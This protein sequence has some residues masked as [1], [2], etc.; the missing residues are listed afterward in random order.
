MMA[1]QPEVAVVSQVNE[2]GTTE[3]IETAR[4]S[5]YETE[6][7]ER[8]GEI[9][10]ISELG[11]LSTLFEPHH[12]FIV[13]GKVYFVYKKADPSTLM[14]TLGAPIAID[15]DDF[16]ALTEKED[17]VREIQRKHDKGEKIETEEIVKYNNI[18][19]SDEMKALT[20]RDLQI[21]KN[22]VIACVVA[23]KLSEED[24]D[25]LSHQIKNELY[26][27]IAGGVT[28]DNTAVQQFR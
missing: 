17:F 24:Y 28:T 15:I 19:A 11:D 2:D 23:P 9:P 10:P 5:N 25:K 3:V 18:L 21:R 26:E 7:K 4:P 27:A 6:T 16:N 14:F 20:K 13:N 1:E 8:I 22:V 12:D